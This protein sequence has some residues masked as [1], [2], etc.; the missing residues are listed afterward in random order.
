MV[1]LWRPWK[2]NTARAREITDQLWRIS[3]N[4]DT[5]RVSPFRPDGPSPPLRC[6]R[7][8]YGYALDGS[9][10]PSHLVWPQRDGQ[11]YTLLDTSTTDTLV[12]DHNFFCPLGMEHFYDSFAL[13]SQICVRTEALSLFGLR[14]DELL[15]DLHITREGV[16]RVG[17]GAH[18]EHRVNHEA[19]AADRTK[20]SAEVVQLAAHEVDPEPTKAESEGG[21]SDSHGSESASDSEQND[22]P[23]SLAADAEQ[24]EHASFLWSFMTKRI[25]LG[26]STANFRNWSWFL[27]DG[28]WRGC[29]FI[30]KNVWTTLTEYWLGVAGKFRQHKEVAAILRAV[31]THEAMMER[32]ICSAL[33]IGYN[34]Q[35]TRSCST[36]RHDTMRP[37][38]EKESDP[39]V[40][41]PVLQHTLGGPKSGS[42]Q[43]LAPA[44]VTGSEGG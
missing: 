10:C 39:A 31:L 32:C 35:S 42:H 15:P 43:L 18:Q 44:F 22:A 7:F 11:S 1:D 17:L 21:T 40:A 24:Y 29:L 13:V 4:E 14:E 27:R 36:H 2:Y 16:L 25:S 30:Y 9:E 34:Q 33:I 41:W 37:G 12:L 19:R 23:S 28:P 20:V 3:H 5:R 8:A 38:K 6:R 26:Q